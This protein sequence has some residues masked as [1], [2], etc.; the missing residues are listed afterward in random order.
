VKKDAKI[1]VAGGKTL[2][3][4]ALLR[5]LKR[6]EYSNIIGESGKEPDQTDASQVDTFLRKNVPSMFFSGWKIWRHR[7]QS[8][9]PGRAYA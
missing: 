2:V 3:G 9:I 1:C 8:E 7:S 4:S 5:E 6:Q